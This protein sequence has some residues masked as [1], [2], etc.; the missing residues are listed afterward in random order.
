[1]N[2]AKIK[3]GIVVQVILC[4]N[5]N[6]ANQKLGGTWVSCGD[7]PVGIG[8]TYTELEGFRPPKPHPDSYWIEL[9]N[10]WHIDPDWFEPETEE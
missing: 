9:E 5:V 4:D 3:D 6:W 8:F 1:M 10:R 2:A 7:C